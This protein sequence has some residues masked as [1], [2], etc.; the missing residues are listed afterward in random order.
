LS[1]LSATIKPNITTHFTTS[2]M[3]NS[4]NI[5]LLLVATAAPSLCAALETIS[6][7]DTTEFTVGGLVVTRIVALQ[8]M[9]DKKTNAA[10]KKVKNMIDNS[11]DSFVI[12]P[13][14]YQPTVGG[15]P[16]R[17]V[18]MGWYTTPK[19]NGSP[20]KELVLEVELEEKD[21]GGQ[22]IKVAQ[23]FNFLPRGRGKSDFVKQMA[24]YFGTPLTPTQL[25]GLK[26]DLL[27]GKPVVV[28]Y[29]TNHLGH[30]VFDK[31][32]APG[33]PAQPVAT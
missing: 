28:H 7:T 3:R 18:D 11:T 5:F 15:K 14:V 8:I 4:F 32:T 21:D 2:S 25:A 19:A 22:P 17:F 20:R 1:A 33:K 26:K 27:V 13:L 24:S 16:G 30:V 23:S 12:E 9:R 6:T 31:Y 10:R 29:T